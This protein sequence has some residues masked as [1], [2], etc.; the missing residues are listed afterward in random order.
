MLSFRTNPS[1]D[2]YEKKKERKISG[3]IYRAAHSRW[4]DVPIGG[5]SIRTTRKKERKKRKKNQ[6]QVCIGG[7]GLT[8]A[9]LKVWK[10]LRWRKRWTEP[11]ERLLRNKEEWIYWIYCGVFYLV[12]E[13]LV[14]D[15]WFWSRRNF[16][17][18]NSERPTWSWGLY[19]GEWEVWNWNCLVENCFYAA[20]I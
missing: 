17:P 10:R 2:S 20:S 3:K 5:F 14:D 16:S 12:E 11:L 18:I 15:N 13:G 19:I 1:F 4:P 6:T 7:G 9:S 8:L